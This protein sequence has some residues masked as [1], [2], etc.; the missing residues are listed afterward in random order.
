MYQ[1]QST[2]LVLRGPCGAPQDEALLDP[3]ATFSDPGIC[4]WHLKRLFLGAAS[5]NVPYA[6]VR[7]PK[8]EASKRAAPLLLAFICRAPASSLEA[9]R[10][11]S[12]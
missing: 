7:S 1:R 8:G 2:R 11:A 5:S 12:G 9:L 4:L 6:E 10:G 3:G